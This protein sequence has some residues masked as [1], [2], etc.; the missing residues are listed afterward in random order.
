MVWRFGQARQYATVFPL[1]TGTAYLPR[2]K[3]SPA[4]GFIDAAAT[5]TE[6]SPQ[7]EHVAISAKKAGGLVRFPAEMA[8]DFVAL[9]QFVARYFARE[10]AKWEDTCLFT[11]DGSSTYKLIK[12][13]GKQAVD[14]SYVVTLASTK[15]HPSDIAIA[16]CRALRAKVD[17]AALR[18]G[19]YYCHPSC[20]AM[21]AGFNTGGNTP[22]LANGMDGPRFDG[23]PIRWVGVMPVFDTGV[24]ASQHQVYFGDL[25]FW[26]LCVMGTPSI[27]PS[28]DVFF[29][30]DEIALRGLSRFDVAQLA[31]GCTAVLRTAAS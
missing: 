24:H 13:V 15:T 18:N 3:T 11:A 6:K 21:F 16:D 7:V 12:G 19:A 1:G 28:R 29:A 9:G 5:V 23:F 4:M 14:D 8:E 22:Y 27:T 25:S 20:E 26:Y 30:T 10:L 31:A 17:G 2:L